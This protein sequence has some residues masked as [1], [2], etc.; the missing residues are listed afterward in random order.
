MAAIIL[1]QIKNDAGAG[2]HEFHGAS[3]HKL[4][5]RVRARVCVCVCVCYNTKVVYTMYHQ[6]LCTCMFILKENVWV[7]SNIYERENFLQDAVNKWKMA[8]KNITDLLK[9]MW[10]L[11]KY[12]QKGLRS[13]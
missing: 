10:K 13:F 9:K 3:Y 2:C 7:F 11:E 6:K 5:V 4:C 8:S 12:P 1:L